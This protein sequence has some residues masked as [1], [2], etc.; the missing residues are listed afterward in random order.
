MIRFRVCW[1]DDRGANMPT[2]IA[3]VNVFQDA[4]IFYAPRKAA[5][6]DGVA[7]AGFVKVADAMLAH[8]IL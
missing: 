4:N 6:A 5:N 1:E 2:T 8:G 3:G 7:I